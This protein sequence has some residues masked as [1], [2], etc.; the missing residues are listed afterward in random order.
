M[1]LLS[2]I[3]I[4]A[5]P[6]WAS[7]GNVFPG[8]GANTDRSAATDWVNPGNI[9]AD[10]NTTA[11]CTGGATG[12]D[13]LIA[14]NFN[15][16]SIPFNAIITG[17]TVRFAA[18]ESSTGSETTTA[19]LQDAAGAL[20]GTSKTNSVNG[21]GETVYTY[22]AANDLWGLNNTTLTAAIVKDADFGCR[23]WYT[24]THNMTVDFV[25]LAVEYAA[26]GGFFRSAS[27]VKILNNNNTK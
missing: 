1:K 15:F 18:A 14:S 13:Y 8:T 12:S 6:F 19:Q 26:G 10:E 9:L 17:I 7:T 4:I 21:T 25:T 22:G 23:F 16:S 27:T 3:L 11:S 20:F 5:M 2:I 24:T